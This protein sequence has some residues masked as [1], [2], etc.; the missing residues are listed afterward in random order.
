MFR[1]I[2]LKIF[3]TFS[4]MAT[5][6]PFV[7]YA[8]AAATWT[9]ATKR[10]TYDRPDLD[11]RYN[12]EYVSASIFDNSDD[13]IYFYLHFTNKPKVDQFNDGKGSWA[14]VGLDY[15]N[16]D[17]SDIRLE[18]YGKT[19]NSDRTS[20][21]GEVYDARTQTFPNCN[22]NVFTNLDE[23]RWWIGFALSRSCIKLPNTFG[24]QG[25]TDYLEK[26]EASFDYAPDDH[27]I[28]NL[29]GANI[30]SEA[31][32]GKKYQLPKNI[33]NE[34]TSLQNFSNSPADLTKLSEK[35]TPSVVTIYCANSKGSGWAIKSELDSTLKGSG[36]KSYVITNHH[37]VE[38]CARSGNVKLQLSDGRS[39]N[40]ILVAWNEE[41][42]VAGIATLDAIPALEWIGSTPKQG[43]WIGV[44]GSPGSL[45]GIL[46][47]G[48]ISSINNE[49]STFTFTAPINPGNSGGPIFDASGR[50]LGL[51]TSKNLLSNGSLAEG[52][53]NGHGV[54][55]LCGSVILC[56]VEK[57]PWGSISKFSAGP[58]ATEFELLAKAEADARAKAEA[59]ARAKAEADA[60]A[61]LE[62]RLREEKL[63][64]CIDSNGDLSV[65]LFTLN[66][67]KAIYP[68]S[69]KIFQGLIDASP[70]PLDCSNINLQAFDTQILNQGKLLSAFEISVADAVANAKIMASKKRTISCVRGTT[71][72]KVTAANPRCPKGFKRK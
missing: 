37:V 23:D 58:S 12:L 2:S 13:E 52:S 31:N 44:L 3:L 17:K 62:L 21:P 61:A 10:D 69:E 22:V 30:S 24:I 65:A 26:D 27:H 36:Y 46:T 18:F 48:I 29:P 16:D 47:T 15:N 49:A 59:D 56:E 7:S 11:P 54:P 68:A 64:Q 28:F 14:F 1:S 67:S 8:E 45:V 71:V 35:L 20:V 40:G 4:L 19:L 63:K 43:W 33:A 5:F 66:S 42:D 55:L 50:V 32:S 6:S 51:A 38:D 9:A 41:S 25:Y 39:I 72:R 70:A 34:S 60:K 57:K 53:G